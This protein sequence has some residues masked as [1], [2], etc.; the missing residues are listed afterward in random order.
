MRYCSIETMEYWYIGLKYRIIGIKWGIHEIVEDLRKLWYWYSEY[1]WR[2]GKKDCTCYF[3]IWHLKLVTVFITFNSLHC[4]YYITLTINPT[5]C[6]WKLF[7]NR[8][9]NRLTSRTLSSIELLLTNILVSTK[10]ISIQ[11]ECSTIIEY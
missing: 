2:I 5:I 8:Q 11:N 10:I 4:L 1:W 3:T 6:P 7:V 9:T